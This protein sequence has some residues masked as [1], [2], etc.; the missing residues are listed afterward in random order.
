MLQCK[1]DIPSASGINY[2]DADEICGYQML[3]CKMYEMEGG[4]KL[5]PVSNRVTSAIKCE[6]LVWLKEV[7]SLIGDIL[8][9]DPDEI[10]HPSGTPV[11]LSAIPGLLHSY[12]FFY[13]VC[14]GTPCYDFLREVKIKTAKRWVKGDK[15]LSIDELSLLIL[16][17]IERDI[18]FLE[19]RFVDFALRQESEW[20]DELKRYG[21]FKDTSLYIACR[22]L[23][24][25]IQTD[26]FVFVGNVDQKEIKRRWVA[27][28]ILTEDKLERLAIKD[29]QAYIT[30]S[31]TAILHDCFP[32]KDHND[33]DEEH[34]RLTAFLLNRL[35]LNHYIIDTLRIEPSC[36]ITEKLH[37]WYLKI[38]NS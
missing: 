8:S 14:N 27:K 5:P 2:H 25:L 22:R 18:R 9:R 15:S 28:Y 7:R 31:D 32:G 4:F 6:G 38:S 37:P 17:E 36:I 1:L 24:H 30:L 21:Y 26:L 3:L 34:T 12:D 23:T 11:D 16:A 33:F 35:D 19:P 29:L 10:S 13:R 20:I